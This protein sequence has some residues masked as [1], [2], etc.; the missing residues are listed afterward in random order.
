MAS[1][2]RNSSGTDFDDVFD[3][4]VQGT[5]PAATGFR[6]S[7]GMDLAGRYAPL[8]FG[9]AAAVQ[10]FRIA[11]G[12]DV[13]TLWAAKGT[14]QYTLP[15]NGKTYFHAYTVPVGGAG[16]S[17]I[18]FSLT[19][20]TAWQISGADTAGTGPVYITG[21]VP[22]AAAS[23]KASFGPVTTIPSTDPANAT[24]TTNMATPTALATGLTAKLQTAVWGQL[25]GTHGSQS[26]ITITFYNASGQPI[27]TSTCTFE[28]ET[29]GSV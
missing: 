18:F 11:G 14:A 15:F 4:Y 25:S 10:G 5:A 20:A 8:S 26:D 3:P 24:W 16:F 6:T 12:A 7:D 22:V 29:D 2:F 21:A 13:N 1:G 9:S 17:A 23:C 28:V 27:S 19:S